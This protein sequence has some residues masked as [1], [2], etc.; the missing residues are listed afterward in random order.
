MDYERYSKPEPVA[1]KQKFF[2]E[3]LRPSRATR[4]K[5][6]SEEHSYQPI[7][8]YPKVCSQLRSKAPRE[9]TSFKLE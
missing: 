1:R 8:K 7:T 6:S 9:K 3:N 2:S 5:L 4:D